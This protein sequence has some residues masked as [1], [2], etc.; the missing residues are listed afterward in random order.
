MAVEYDQEPQ[1]DAWTDDKIL[2]IAIDIG[3]HQLD[4]LGLSECLARAA[5]QLWV[6]NAN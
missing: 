2:V 6:D 3:K 5:S 4:L 1:V